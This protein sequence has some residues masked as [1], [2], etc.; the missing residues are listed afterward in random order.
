MQRLLCVHSLGLNHQ[1]SAGLL[2]QSLAP[3]CFGHSRWLRRVKQLLIVHSIYSSGDAY[4]VEG[5]EEKV[6][7]PERLFNIFVLQSRRSFH[8]RRHSRLEHRLQR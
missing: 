7:R 8:I 5:G 1:G 2:Q 6:A 4:L 3:N